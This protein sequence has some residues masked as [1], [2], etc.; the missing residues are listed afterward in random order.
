[1]RWLMMTREDDKANP[2]GICRVV[3]TGEDSGK[4]ASWREFLNVRLGEAG[5]DRPCS[6]SRCREARA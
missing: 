1:L 4:N 5:S 2:F 3:M 6:V